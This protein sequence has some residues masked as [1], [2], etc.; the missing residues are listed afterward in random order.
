MHLNRAWKKILFIASLIFLPQLINLSAYAEDVA[1]ILSEDYKIY[2]LA[3]DGFK[4]S[5]NLPVKEYA[6]HGSLEEGGRIVESIKSQGP[7]LIFALGNKACQLVKANISNTPVVFAMI[8][9]PAQYDL[10]G[11][12]ICGVRM[13][14]P[15]RE[16][17]IFL[18]KICPQVKKVGAVYN[19]DR[20]QKIIDEGKIEAV[21]LG[22]EIIAAKAKSKAEVSEAINNLEGKIDAFWMIPD[23]LVANSIVLERLLLLTLGNKIPL[24]C[25][26]EDFVKNGGMFSID[27]DYQDIGAQSAGIA[28]EILSGS[29]LP[30]Q[31]GIQFPRKTN[32]II[33]LKIANKIGLALSQTIINEAYKV[34]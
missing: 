19:P 8:I 22:L 10:T 2:S 34:Y 13:D 30:G 31:I 20:S 4:G 17:L 33:N 25:P 5:C 18:K 1:V 6:M 32:L 3:L 28:N 12:N 26:A 15:V 14:M 9:N 23:S 29:R 24:I 21:N 11:K 16:Q 27:A 7:K